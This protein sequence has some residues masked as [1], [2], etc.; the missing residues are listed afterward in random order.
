MPDVF[1]EL[2]AFDGLY[3]EMDL[4]AGLF[5]DLCHETRINWTRMVV[6]CPAYALGDPSLRRIQG[7]IISKRKDPNCIRYPI[8]QPKTNELR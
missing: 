3:P 5:G 6:V 7:G 1:V 4:K 8:P 2:M